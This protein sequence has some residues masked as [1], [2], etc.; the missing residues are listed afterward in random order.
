MF[1]CSKLCMV[2]HCYLLTCTT[3]SSQI[4]TGFFFMYMADHTKPATIL[5]AHSFLY[6]IFNSRMCLMLILWMHVR[7]KA[8]STDKLIYTKLA[9]VTFPSMYC[10][11]S[12]LCAAVCVSKDF[13]FFFLLFFEHCILS[14]VKIPRFTFE[15]QN[16]KKNIDEWD[17]QT[18]S[19]TE[20]DLICMALEER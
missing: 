12:S 2:F 19:T 13:N 18:I 1:T 5:S 9:F 3:A 7:N 8:S 17:F 20:V 14:H 10:L 6:N 4:F 16:L 15:K 11:C